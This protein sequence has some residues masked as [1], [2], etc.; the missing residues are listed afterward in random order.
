[1]SQ[2][3]LIQALLGANPSQFAGINAAQSQITALAKQ[4][5]QEAAFT[6]FNG[7]LKDANATLKLQ[8]AEQKKATATLE[9]KVN[10]LIKAIE[11]IIAGQTAVLS[12]SATSTKHIVGASGGR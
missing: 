4:T 10:Q 11:N 8:L 7:Q 5:G 2:L 12:R 6:Q 1:M 3:P 9:T